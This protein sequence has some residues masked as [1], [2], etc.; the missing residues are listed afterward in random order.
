MS[1]CHCM[2]RREFIG[3]GTLALSAGVMNAALGPGT[4]TRSREVWA[5]PWDPERPQMIFGR[6]LV[7]QPLLRHLIETPKPRTSWR[8]W[9]G[10]HTEEAVRDEQQ[11][12][13]VELASLAK[14][15]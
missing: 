7:V 10:V 2:N 13:A 1:C 9:G 8:N 12:I 14:K 5:E 3:A 4:D 15:A 6:K 11:R